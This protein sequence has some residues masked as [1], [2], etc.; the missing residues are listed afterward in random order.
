MRADQ[1]RSS[2][3]LPGGTWSAVSAGARPCAGPC[4]LTS[5]RV[6]AVLGGSTA[7]VLGVLLPALWAHSCPSL[8]LLSHLLIAWDGAPC[9]GLCAQLRTHPFSVLQG[10]PADLST[11]QPSMGLGCACERGRLTPGPAPG[12]WAGMLDKGLVLNILPHWARP[13]ES[14]STLPA[15][16]LMAC[17]GGAHR[18]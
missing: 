9:Q 6:D 2:E 18:P 5:V 8:E 1:K 14:A 3:T 4:S 13:R 7:E 15:W 11:C 17:V 12:C 16:P 10:E